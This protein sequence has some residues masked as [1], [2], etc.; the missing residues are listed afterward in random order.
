MTSEIADF[1]DAVSHAAA[2]AAGATAIVTRNLDDFRQAII[3][4]FS[5]EIFLAGLS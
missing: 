1:E 2:L 5:P 3:P 4:V